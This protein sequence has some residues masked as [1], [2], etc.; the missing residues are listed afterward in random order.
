MSHLNASYMA[1]VLE[2]VRELRTQ[3]QEGIRE[4]L[5]GAPLGHRTPN[6]RE[7]LAWWA[8]K[9]AE[10]PPVPILDGRTGQTIVR[11]PFLLALELA[12]NGKEWQQRYA[13]ALRREQERAAERFV[14]MATSGL[15]VEEA[16]TYG[17]SS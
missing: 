9:L 15:T 4:Q 5:A 1:D 3:D 14:G 11:S 12:E 7:F 8:Q 17:T 6:D 2:R 13:A 10:N 16:M